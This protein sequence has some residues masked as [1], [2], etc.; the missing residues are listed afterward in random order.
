[1]L[2]SIKKDD[3]YPDIDVRREEQ[4]ISCGH[5]VA[6]CPT[7]SLSHKDVPIEK[8]PPINKRLRINLAQAQQFLRSRRSIRAFKH[9]K[10]EKEVIQNLIEIARYAPTG[11]NKQLVQWCV[12]TQRAQLDRLARETVEYLRHRTNTNPDHPA[13]TIMRLVVAAWDFGSDAVLWRA[14]A[15]LVASAPK[16]AVTGFVDVVLT[17]SYLELAATT[18]GLG[19]CWIGMFRDALYSWSP[20]QEIVKLPKDHIHFYPMALGYPKNEYD[21]LP[22]RKAPTIDW[23]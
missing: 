6:V 7:G 9:K 15:L 21:R 5:C 22:E 23:R 16:S 3:G 13:A 17:L 19:T 8:S 12:F 14:P 11:T 10:V 2:I 4:C 20:I 18:M 1:L